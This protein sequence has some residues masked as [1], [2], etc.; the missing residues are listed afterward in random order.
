MINAVKP[1]GRISW[2]LV[3][4]FPYLWD[5]QHHMFLKPTV[6]VDFAQRVGHSFQYEYEA[7]PTS[8]TYL[9]LLDLVATTRAAISP[10]EPQDNIDIQ[11][12]IWVVGAYPQE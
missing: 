12:F 11:S 4:Y 10:L 7:E 3:T 5:Y 1:H 2:P 6:T 8:G 9:S